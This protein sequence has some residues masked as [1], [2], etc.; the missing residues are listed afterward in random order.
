MKI[1]CFIICAICLIMP[2]NAAH[3]KEGISITKERYVFINLVLQYIDL[4]NQSQENDQKDY[5]SIVNTCR[6]GVFQFHKDSQT[7]EKYVDIN[8][9]LAFFL[10][11]K[12]RNSNY[13]SLI[14]FM[15]YGVNSYMNSVTKSMADEE[16]QSFI[17]NTKQLKLNINQKIDQKKIDDLIAKIQAF[18]EVKTYLKP[19]PYNLH[20]EQLPEEHPELATALAEIFEIVTFDER[21]L[22][23]TL[24]DEEKLIRS[25]YLFN[26]YSVT[27]IE[28]PILLARI[29]IF[30]YRSEHM[31][32]GVDI[33]QKWLAMENPNTEKLKAL[34]DKYILAL[35]PHE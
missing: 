30:F 26:H 27:D 15:A 11:E 7:R 34:F 3:A 21:S 29:L 19:A 33:S 9:C 35:H 16:K 8:K 31:K 12:N 32:Q 5:H 17:S 13:V 14:Y 4:V 28:R 24:I 6:Y 22:K 10:N 1:K 25:Y 20:L 23:N 2:F 18:N